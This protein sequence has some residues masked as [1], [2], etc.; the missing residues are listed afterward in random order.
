MHSIWTNIIVLAVAAMFLAPVGVMFSTL[1]ANA[2]TTQQI[3]KGNC[4]SCA[5]A[6]KKAITH[7]TEKKGDYNKASVT[8]ALKDCVSV[9]Q[10][11]SQLLARSSGL[12][13]KSVAICIEACLKAAQAMDAFPKDAEMQACANECRKCASNLEKTQKG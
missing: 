4:D 13:K 12:E 5:E 2:Q 6:C 9:C 10:S 8:G 1:Q 3:V 7:C 11:T